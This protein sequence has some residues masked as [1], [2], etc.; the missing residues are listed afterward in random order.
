MTSDQ[1][2]QVYVWVLLP[3]D[4]QPNLCGRLRISEGVDG[5]T[6]AEF[7][8]GRSYLQ[9][10]HANPLDPIRL[11]LAPSAFKATSQASQGDPDVFGVIAD[12]CPDD[13]GRY[14]ITRRHGPQR[15]PIGFLLR[16]QEDRVGNLCF[17]RE[18]GE[19]PLLGEPVHAELLNDAWA[20]VVG[21]DTGRPLPPDLENR[22][23]ANTG[24]GGARPKLTVSDGAHQWLAKFPSH[25]D[26]RRYSQAR[27][28]AATLDLAERAGITAAKAKLHEVP[29]SANN[30]GGVITLVRRFDR[31][32]E[33]GGKGWLR[34]A[35]VSARTVLSS[36]Q[37]SRARAYMGSYPQLAEQLQ[38]WSSN[39]TADRRELYRRM[40]FNCCVSNTDDH[41]RNHGL[42]AD[43]MGTGMRLSPAFDIVPRLHNTVRRYQSLSVS[44][45]SALATVDNLL[46]SA[47]RFAIPSAEARSIIDDVQ[48]AVAKHWRDCLRGRGM[49]PA[50]LELLT[51]CFAELPKNEAHVERLIQ[52]RS[53]AS[54]ASPA[55][56]RP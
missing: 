25:R 38:R 14:V 33:P 18:L 2:D 27:L 48:E 24:M 22:V 6:V 16:S 53:E 21:L 3:G 41:D 31:T 12:A 50:E 56:P 37:G 47:D 35:Y 42:L 26:D 11:P 55:R 28:E 44:D 36:E 4:V 45:D 39:P 9:L 17:G 20:V 40:V 23:R 54:A 5:G 8:Y 34:D 13:W 10:K 19:V 1:D 7:V 51:P 29:A 30:P 52:A 43:E 46:S 15:F 49:T 32:W